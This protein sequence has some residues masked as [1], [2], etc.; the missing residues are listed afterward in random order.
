MKLSNKHR[1]YKWK[2]YRALL[3]ATCVAMLAFPVAGGMGAM[4]SYYRIL[5]NGQEVGVADSAEH[6]KQAYQQARLQYNAKSQDLT[7]M[8][9]DV[10]YEP[11]KGRVGELTSQEELTAQLSQQ[12]DEYAEQDH[13]L[14]YTLKINNYTVTLS[15]KE[16]V[17][18]VLEQAQAQYDASDEF[19]VEL[20]KSTEDQ[21]LG[22][23]TTSV[24]NASKTANNP[25][26]VAAASGENVTATNADPST[27]GED[28]ILNVD[29][30]EQVQV[31][32]TYV[33]QDQL[34]DVQTALEGITKEK[35][36]NEVYQVQAG[37][38]LST[39]AD[40]YGMSTTDLLA[41][42][43]GMTVDSNLLIGDQ[44]VVMVPKPELSILV[45]E[46]ATYTE[47]YD[48]EVQY[49][50][51]PDVYVG[52]N[53]VLQEASQGERTVTAIINYRNGAEYNRQIMNEVIITEA[54][55]K[56][57]ERGTK[58]LPTYIRPTSYG[59]MSSGFGPRWGT[60]HKGI[61][62]SVPVGTTARASRAG[63][64][65]SAGWSG[66]YG[67]CVIIDHG[68]GVK[69]RYAH[70]SKILVSSGQ[71]VD[72]GDSI[73]LTGNTGDSTGPHIHFEVIVNGVPVNP[74]NYI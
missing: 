10:T 63:Q 47:N 71:Y 70:L 50:D 29:F 67:Y 39:I 55:P 37:D 15:S 34:C 13:M 40:L 19:I 59:S 30:Q 54:V 14:A 7:L 48:A 4:K 49:V 66:G 69:T 8:N 28:G 42:N 56:I 21:E 5:I 68:D 6:A 44:V 74:L 25:A 53:T 61:D 43:P 2:Q 57:V 9:I 36:E 20:A 3:I 73:A 16:E 35:E 46:Q 31:L 41:I 58:A 51:N 72:Q 24:L 60:T 12:L 11:A 64:V 62:W 27:L 32:E 65:V 38:C 22:S 17:L 52:T 23:M 1:N 45:D 18:Q 26:L 33:P